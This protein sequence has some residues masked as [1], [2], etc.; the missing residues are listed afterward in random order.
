M[1]DYVVQVA[2]RLE[3]II[4]EEFA[5]VEYQKRNCRMD[6]KLLANIVGVKDVLQEIEI[7][8]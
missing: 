7:F 5:F 8:I 6:S 1:R 3:T 4:L 2:F